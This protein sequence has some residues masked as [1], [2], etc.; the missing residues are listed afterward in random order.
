MGQLHGKQNFNIQNVTVGPIEQVLQLGDLVDLL[1]QEA[2]F[3]L[4]KAIDSEINNKL[5]ILFFIKCKEIALCKS[6]IGDGD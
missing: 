5:L 6:K 1:E 4:I 3:E 2:T